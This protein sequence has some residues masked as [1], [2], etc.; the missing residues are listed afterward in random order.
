MDMNAKSSR[1]ENPEIRGWLKEIDSVRKREKEYR[2]NASKVVKIYEAEEKVDFQF[3]ILYSNTETMLPALY[4]STPR[5]D[6][7]PRYKE[8]GELPM[9]AS[10][11]AKRVLEFMLDTDQAEYSRFDDAMVS[12]VLQALV[13]G[14][15]VT[16]FKYD[17]T[18]EQAASTQISEATDDTGGAAPASDGD[19]Q[20]LASSGGERV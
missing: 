11:V 2:D 9:L 13:P 12:A 3:N 5:P 19:N 20:Q 16:R 18:A 14:R 7:Q 1:A 8:Q 10:K 17:Y 4:N 15:G 6:V